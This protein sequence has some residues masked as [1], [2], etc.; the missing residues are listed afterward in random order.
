MAGVARDVVLNA[1]R[2]QE[3]IA[4]NT[5]ISACPVE[6]AR[7]QQAIMDREAVEAAI[8]AEKREA[9]KKQDEPPAGTEGAQP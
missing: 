9:P 8:S 7:L 2:R 1:L 4:W 6:A 3:E 5:L